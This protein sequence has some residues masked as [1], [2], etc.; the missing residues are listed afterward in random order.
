MKKTMRFLGAVFTVIMLL[1]C[2]QVAFAVD[3]TLTTDAPITATLDYN[4]RVYYADIYFTPEVEGTYKVTFKGDGHYE[5][6]LDDYIDCDEIYYTEIVEHF[7]AD[8][9]YLFELSQDSFN[10]NEIKPI[11]IEVEI[12]LLCEH[13]NTSTI[14]ETDFTCTQDG[15]TEKIIC[16]DCGW[17]LKESFERPARHLDADNDYVCDVCSE[18]AVLISGQYDNTYYDYETDIETPYTTKYKFYANGD[19]YI[20]GTDARFSVY[21]AKVLYDF[22]KKLYNPDTDDYDLKVRNVYVGKDMAYFDVGSNYGVERFIVDPEN[23]EYSTDSYGILFSKDGKEL[24]AVPGLWKET[25]YDIPEGVESIDSFTFTNAKYLETVTIP[26]SVKY[27]SSYVF[28]TRILTCDET[29][30]GLVYIGDALIE[31]TDEEMSVVKIREGTRIIAEDVGIGDIVYEIP[32]SLEFISGALCSYASAYIVDENNNH[33]SDIDGVLFNKDKS[34]LIAYPGARQESSYVVPDGVK[35]IGDYAFYCSDIS[36]I[37]LPDG[38][39]RIGASA[40]NS[41]DIHAVELPLSVKEID[42]WAFDTEVPIEAVVLHK[43]IKKLGYRAFNCETLAILNPECEIEYIAGYTTLIVGYNGSTTE[44][45]ANENNLAFATFGDVN[46][47]N[48]NHI[49]FPKT[50]TTATCTVNGEESFSC[51]CGNTETYIRT[52]EATG[53]NW[54]YMGDGRYCINCDEFEIVDDYDCEC[55]CHEDTNKFEMFFFK[56]KVF[57]WKLFRTNRYCYCGDYHW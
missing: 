29:I 49:Y 22:F 8:Y 56:I 42:D 54:Y 14:P 39:E 5:V 55:K 48:H 51:P 28:N 44:K 18:E 9:Q 43:N 57:F 37:E 11:N 36:H 7:K 16:D 12:T 45:Y 47:E 53:H 26:S 1:C 38:L 32:A 33:F 41:T 27:I 15:G 34:V 13:K 31:N 2:T 6:Y 50:I 24:L 10:F 21:S 52:V 40:F 17:V 25:S 23:K 4:N 46:G 20:D 35:E 30:D 19:L 3:Y